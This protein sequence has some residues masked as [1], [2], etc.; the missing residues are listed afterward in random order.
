MPSNR[1]YS[2]PMFWI[3]F[4]Y[5]WSYWLS[6]QKFFIIDFGLLCS[7]Q[8]RPALLY[9]CFLPWHVA[10]SLCKV[11]RFY[12]NLHYCY[13]Y[14]PDYMGQHL[15]ITYGKILWCKTM[16]LLLEMCDFLVF[17]IID[18]VPHALH[19]RGGNKPD[20]QWPT[21]SKF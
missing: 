21:L 1:T 6:H 20:V 15:T 14:I 4:F 19:Q 7:P 13:A 2:M 17:L 18:R 5:Y 11:S 12:H 9:L 10:C 16:R 8:S 3:F